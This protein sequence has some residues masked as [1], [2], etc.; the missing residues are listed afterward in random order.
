MSRR[1]LG[2]G[3]PDAIVFSSNTHDFLVRL[4]AAAPGDAAAAARADERRRIPQRA[5]PV[6]ALGGRR[7]DRRSS[8]SPPSRS[9]AS[10]SASCAAREAGE[11]DFI[12]VSQVLFGS[13]RIVRPGRGACRA[14]PA[15]RPVGR[16]RRLSRVHGARPAVRRGGAAEVRLLPRRRLQIC[17][18]GRGLRLHACARRLRP[19]AA[20][21]RLV[22]RVR[23]SEPCRREASAMPR[24]R[25]ASL[26]RRSIHRRSTAST[27]C[28]GCWRRTA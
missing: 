19:A 22:R 14:R 15:G 12:F 7:L 25:A 2:T 16:D 23:G 26:A 4:V 24:T 3:E 17:D 9:T 13:G 6:R 18:G 8:A 1:E 28:G 21:H 11:H 10:P 20:D 27:R 5:A